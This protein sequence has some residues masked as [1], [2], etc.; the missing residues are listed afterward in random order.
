MTKL[1]ES[2][3]TNATKDDNGQ[4][5]LIFNFLYHVEQDLICLMD[6]STIR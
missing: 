3:V 5:W 4:V 2:L 1:C 6:K